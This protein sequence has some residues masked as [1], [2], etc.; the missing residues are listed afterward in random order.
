MLKTVGF[1]S[2]RTGDQTIVNGNE[3][4]ATAGKGV[5]FTAN[6]PAAGMTS[7]LLNWYE[8]GTFT[9]VIEGDSGAG[10]GTY[11]IQ[12]GYYTRI[13]RQVSV[14]I[15]LA[16]TAHTGLGNIRVNGL[17]F[18]CNTNIQAAAALQAYN[19]TLSA[20]NYLIGRVEQNTTYISLLQSPTG[21]GAW[22]NVPM[23]TSVDALVINVTY[24]I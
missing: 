14:Q 9:P 20:N 4:F 21:G 19:L 16:W 8:E 1:P 12:T 23:D 15:A 10:T 22:V 18:T 13:G 2:T 7:Q 6:T 24:I 11:T 3:V 5:N 17:P